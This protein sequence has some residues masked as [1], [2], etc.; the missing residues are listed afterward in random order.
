MNHCNGMDGIRNYS[1]LD[2]TV[3]FYSVIKQRQVMTVCVPLSHWDTCIHLSLCNHRQ[4][5]HIH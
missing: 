1:L 3:Y 2:L 4:A 5:F